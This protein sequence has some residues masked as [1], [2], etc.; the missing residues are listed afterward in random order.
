MP[1]AAGAAYL[2]AEVAA[3]NAEVN[4]AG[5]VCLHRPQVRALEERPAEVL[6]GRVAGPAN[7]YSLLGAARHG[8]SNSNSNKKQKI[9]NLSQTTTIVRTYDVGEGSADIQ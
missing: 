7:P 2:L 1:Y 6:S 5:V 3:R 8:N 4:T 9:E